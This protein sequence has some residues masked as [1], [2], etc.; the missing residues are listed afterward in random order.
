MDIGFFISVEQDCFNEL[1][2]IITSH[3]LRI[4]HN[5]SHHLKLKSSVCCY[6][7]VVIGLTIKKTTNKICLKF[8]NQ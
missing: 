1:Q 4:F 5:L 8:I 3:Y 7:H 2:S 6:R